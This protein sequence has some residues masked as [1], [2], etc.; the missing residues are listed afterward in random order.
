MAKSLFIVL[1][2]IDGSGKSEMINRL[3][4]YIFSLNKKYRILSTREPTYGK[5][6]KQARE[7]LLNDKNPEKNSEKCLELFVKDRKEHLSALV[8]PF[9]LQDNGDN[10]NI[11][12]CDR[13]YYSTIA[14]QSAQGLNIKEIIEKNKRFLKPT[15]A[16]VLDLPVRLALER[17]GIRGEAKEKFEQ[18]EFMIKLRRNFLELRNRLDDNLVII[19]ASKSRDKVFESIRERVDKYLNKKYKK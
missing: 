5:Y 4:N 8:K 17:L 14:F 2:G 7:I 12:L 19:S 18:K 9:L 6:G 13:Y 3:H 16:F 15:V 1:D 11:V 10:V